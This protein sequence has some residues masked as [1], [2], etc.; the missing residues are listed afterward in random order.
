MDKINAASYTRGC[1]SCE[2]NQDTL[3]QIAPS[4]S[5]NRSLKA[6]DE[7]KGDISEEVREDERLAACVVSAGG[8]RDRAMARSHQQEVKVEVEENCP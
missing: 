6:A 7:D 5:W 8:V 4:E 1:W 2:E 3:R